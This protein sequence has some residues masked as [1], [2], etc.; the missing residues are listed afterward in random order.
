MGEAKRRKQLDPNYGKAP[1]PSWRI[2]LVDRN[3]LDFAGQSILANVYL[4]YGWHQFK[5][6]ATYADDTLDGFSFTFTATE[7]NSKYFLEAKAQVR[8][9]MGRRLEEL[10][11]EAGFSPQPR[12]NV[13][14]TGNHVVDY[15]VSELMA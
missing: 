15:K 14:R 10:L 5:G 9:E 2:A 3:A 11:A 13:K 8:E 4:D 7:N 6:W 1:V 12:P